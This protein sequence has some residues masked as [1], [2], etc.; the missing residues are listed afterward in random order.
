MPDAPAQDV[1][2]E[3]APIGRSSPGGGKIGPLPV[4]GWALVAGGILIFFFWQK[5]KGALPT[6][7]DV[8]GSAGGGAQTGVTQ[9]DPMSTA[10]LL[11]AMQD[12]AARLGKTE[13]S[14]SPPSTASP[15]K[16]W[17]TTI[18][19]INTWGFPHIPGPNPVITAISPVLAEAVSST[20]TTGGRDTALSSNPGV[21][22]IASP[23]DPTYNWYPSAG[24]ASTITTTKS[25]GFL[26]FTKKVTTTTN[27]NIG[28]TYNPVKPR[29]SGN[30][31]VL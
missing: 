2:P 19:P 20:H 26:D 3:G 7:T 18:P 27:P 1:T 23:I 14:P 17:D 12:L 28:K 11:Q 22:A 10:A 5:S 29:S 21:P 15:N 31:A 4:W 8:T 30:Q 13:V 16:S 25:A 24:K 6:S 9:T